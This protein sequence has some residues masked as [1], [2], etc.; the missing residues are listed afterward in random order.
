MSNF[1]IW[2]YLT[3]SF[4][5]SDVVGYAQVTT[6]EVSSGLA[7]KFAGCGC[8]HLIDGGLFAEN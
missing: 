1:S 2:K 7:V 3:G 6:A 5:G 8:V 4:S